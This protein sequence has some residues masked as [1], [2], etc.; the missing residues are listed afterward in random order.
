MPDATP[1]GATCDHREVARG[2]PPAP[3]LRG[4]AGELGG[5]TAR[6]REEGGTVTT[7]ELVRHARAGTRDERSQGR[8][9]QRPLSAEG[10]VQARSLAEELAAGEPIVALHTSPLAR[11]RQTLEPLAAD[12]G[13]PLVDEEA[14]AEAPGVPVVDAGSLWVASAWLGGRA[15]AFLDRLVAEH[16]HGRVVCCSHGDVLPALLALLAARDGLPITDVHLK[17]GARATLRFV[18]GRCAGVDW[19]APPAGARGAGLPG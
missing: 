13:L 6:R 8:D 7:V 17:K 1:G 3:T 16:P 4:R 19:T 9:W 18:G 15:V 11:C 10:W 14:L 5:L 12:L 2:A